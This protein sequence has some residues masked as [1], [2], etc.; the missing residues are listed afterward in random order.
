MK[1]ETSGAAIQTLRWRLKPE[2][3]PDLPTFWGLC[4]PSTWHSAL[5]PLM[6]QPKFGAKKDQDERHLPVRSLNH[7]MFL[8][9]DTL[10]AV[11][12]EAGKD[13]LEGTS[14]RPWLIAESPIVPDLIARA[15]RAWIPT[16]FPQATV[17]ALRAAQAK[18]LPAALT[19]T[20]RS[21][22]LNNFDVT[23]NG[24]ANPS[25]ADYW[26]IPS[27][28]VRH[29]LRVTPRL[30]LNLYSDSGEVDGKVSLNLVPVRAAD[31]KMELMSWPPFT[32]GKKRIPAWSLV[33]SWDLETVP[34]D[35][36]PWI[37]LNVSV[38]RW[39]IGKLRYDRHRAYIRRDQP[40]FPG[41]ATSSVF[42][43][44]Q[45]THY[46]DEMSWSDD[47]A[48]VLERLQ[49]NDAFPEPADLIEDRSGWIAGQGGLSVAVLHQNV[50][51]H[52]IKNGLSPAD[53]QDLFE[54][55]NEHFPMLQHAESNLEVQA[56]SRASAKFTRLVARLAD[57]DPAEACK[58][59]A[60][61][62]GHTGTILLATQ[63]SDSESRIREVLLDRF[64]LRG[65]SGLEVRTVALGPLAALLGDR[66]SAADRA[67]A[68]S[69]FLNR[70][71]IGCPLGGII[72]LDNWSDLGS[73]RK[74]PKN[75]IRAGFRKAGFVSQFITPEQ[76]DEGDSALAART[77]AAVRDS[78]RGIG[79]MTDVVMPP[80]RTDAI[81]FIGDDPLAVMGLATLVRERWYMPVL[82]RW[83][84]GALATEVICPR[85][86]LSRWLG[87]R[88]AGLAIGS[89]PKDDWYDVFNPEHHEAVRHWLLKR[90]IEVT[91]RTLLVVEANQTRRWWPWLSNSR[92]TGTLQFNL[93]GEDLPQAARQNIRLVRCRFSPETPSYFVAQPAVQHLKAGLFRDGDDDRWYGV[94]PRNHN[95]TI[96]VGFHK[97]QSPSLLGWIPQAV[98]LLP[99]GFD[100]GEDP[101]EAVAFAHFLRRMNPH[102]DDATVM[103]LPIHLA[104]KLKENWVGL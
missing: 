81:G 71:D 14:G 55:V 99:A 29:A 97:V 9:F 101:V 12:K 98:E 61:S 96:P 40:L 84:A 3:Y 21:L 104:R 42:A 79:Y 65:L 87:Y 13:P 52:P 27:L 82:V 31:G 35:R 19:W 2:L 78:L 36:L 92:F 91:E 50:G 44:A 34:G 11:E 24:T 70:L 43:T 22:Q 28:L 59:F 10:V 45:F 7:L 77:L 46:S 102:Y 73:S 86:P 32:W 58:A 62:V 72:E 26:L 80:F 94:H 5:K 63:S 37:Q 76:T 67:V 17:D 56:Y 1:A 41:M 39:A 4:F 60:G 90:L 75:A 18:I 23:A 57:I 30:S 68:V 51:R 54:L 100:A 20:T 103:P 88:E 25:S 6:P 33:W 66:E 48:S 53:H 74:D 64:G 47:L 93:G 89:L 8:L 95:L 49:R 69:S 15:V 83:S 38:R 85:Q 16:A